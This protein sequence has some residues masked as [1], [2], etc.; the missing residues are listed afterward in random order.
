MSVRVLGHWLR[1]RRVARQR[2]EIWTLPGRQMK[3]VATQARNAA[4]A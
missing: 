1:L 2:A 4:Q 3:T